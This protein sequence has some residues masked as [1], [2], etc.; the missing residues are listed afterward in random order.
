M[1]IVVGIATSG[2]PDVLADTVE[3]LALQL[4][5]PDLVIICPAS[6]ADL[7]NARLATSTLAVLVVQGPKGSCHQRNAIIDAAPDADLITFLDDDFVPA[8]DFLAQAELLFGR[9][10]AIAA[11]TGDVLADGVLGVGLS[12]AE[13]ERIIAASDPDHTSE[14]EDVY[15]GYGCNLVV[16]M[17]HV[18]RHTIR[19]DENLPLY[20]WQEDVD[21]SRQL[22][23]FGR[24]VQSR[25]LR[26]VH[27]GSKRG[28][29]KGLSF[30]YSQIAN[31]IYLS[32]KGTVSWK[33]S[34]PQILRNVA[35]NALHFPRPEIWIDRRGRLCGNLLGI[36]DLCRGRLDPNRILQF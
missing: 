33:H 13:A 20:A 12:L 2:R 8:G 5:R 19:F 15:N 24:I 18:R 14:A 21:L 6:P 17:A 1:R 16:R 7:N 32:K 10:E 9:D 29:G 34:L 30:G 35:S 31:P 27:L 36:L 26:G 3:L 11:A 4:R 28:P 23:K 22:A 25:R